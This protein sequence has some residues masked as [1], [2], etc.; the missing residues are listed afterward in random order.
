M[1]AVIRCRDHPLA[2]RA[3]EREDVQIIGLI[4]AVEMPFPETC[5]GTGRGRTASGSNAAERLNISAEGIPIALRYF[6]E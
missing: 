4:S 3:A 6:G 1:T 2:A 5:R